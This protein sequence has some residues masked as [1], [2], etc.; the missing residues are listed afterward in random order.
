MR[1]VPRHEFVSLRRN[2]NAAD[3]APLP[4]GLEHIIISLPYIAALMIDLIRP[5]KSPQI[6][7]L[8]MGSG[9]R[10]AVP[11]EIIDSVYTKKFYLNWLQRRY[12]G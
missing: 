5:H 12:G 2:S 9:Y 1:T 6:L 10:A 8:G 4:I 7:E 3:D 11:A